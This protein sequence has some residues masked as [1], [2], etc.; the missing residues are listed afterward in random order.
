MICLV[1]RKACHYSNIKK[2]QPSASNVV[3]GSNAVLT[4]TLNPQNVIVE[5]D[6]DIASAPP[7]YDD[8]VKA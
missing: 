3:V 6:N 8:I 7:S 2:K 4:N 5:K 1:I